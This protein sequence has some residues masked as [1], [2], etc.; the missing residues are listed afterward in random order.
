MDSYGTIDIEAK[1]QNILYSP[2][3]LV[4]KDF[5]LI[6]NEKGINL[7]ENSK[8]FGDYETWNYYHIMSVQRVQSSWFTS[9]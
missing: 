2:T 3:M 8:M 1:I 4:L 7:K 9:L 6:F 5:F